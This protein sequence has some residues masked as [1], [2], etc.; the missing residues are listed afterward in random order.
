M[1]G[2]TYTYLTPSCLNMGRGIGRTIA[3]TV[4]NPGGWLRREAFS[5]CQRTHTVRPSVPSN[6]FCP[7]L[8]TKNNFANFFDASERWPPGAPR[9]QGSGDG[10]R[11]YP[12]PLVTMLLFGGF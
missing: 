12:V 8:E 4:R 5:I 1:V 7:P 10:H 3:A 9:G 11:L 6:K 2:S